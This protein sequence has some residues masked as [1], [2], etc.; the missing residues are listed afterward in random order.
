LHHLFILENLVGLKIILRKTC[1]FSIF[2]IT[3]K[4]C[5]IMIH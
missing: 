2:G 5:A 4:T 1:W 3:I